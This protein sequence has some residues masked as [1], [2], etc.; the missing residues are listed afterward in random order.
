MRDEMPK[1]IQTRT[2]FVLWYEDE[3]YYFCESNMRCVPW[4][5]FAREDRNV[6]RNKAPA[7]LAELAAFY[8]VSIKPETITQG[9][10]FD[11]KETI[12]L[13]RS[14]ITIR[15]ISVEA[16]VD[17]PHRNEFIVPLKRHPLYPRMQPA[18]YKPLVAAQ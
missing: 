9:L 14:L 10:P 12:F 5:F 18:S 15:V 1:K 7:V 6:P 13:R 4:R 8:G 17:I 11:A 2:I 3:H 16:A